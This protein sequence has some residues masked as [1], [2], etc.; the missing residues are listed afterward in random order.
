ML[1]WKQQWLQ[2][3]AARLMVGVSKFDGIT[4][5]LASLHWLPTVSQ[6]RFKVLKLMYK[7]F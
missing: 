6:I 5:V 2:N 4:P 7:V 3:T 1:T